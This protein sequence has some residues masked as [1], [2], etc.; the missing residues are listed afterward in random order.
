MARHQA[1]LLSGTTSLGIAAE[2]LRTT[3]AHHAL[4]SFFSF[5]DHHGPRLVSDAALPLVCLTIGRARAIFNAAP[6]K[7]GMN[8]SWPK[9]RL[10]RRMLGSKTSRPRTGLQAER[11]IAAVAG[12]CGGETACCSCKHVWRVV[13]AGQG[14]TNV[15][16]F[17]RHADGR[18]GPSGC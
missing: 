15:L 10:L 7:G 17:S 9:P 12:S 11:K 13:A 16:H 1:N 18:S 5:T 4:V 3:L 2:L 14:K 6:V 8:D